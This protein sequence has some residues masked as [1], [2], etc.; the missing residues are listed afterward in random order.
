VSKATRRQYGEG[1][2][3]EYNARGVIRYR[4]Q[5][6]EPVDPDEPEAGQLRRSK[7]DSPPRSRRARTYATRWESL[8][9]GNE[10]E[11]LVTTSR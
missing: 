10:V 8:T 1:S 7:G 3:Y 5:W 9:A 2:I 4:V 6:L 11:A